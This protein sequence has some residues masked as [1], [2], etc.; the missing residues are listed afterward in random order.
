MGRFG[1][2]VRELIK[3]LEALPQYVPVVCW[4]SLFGDNCFLEIQ[5]TGLVPLRRMEEEQ[6]YLE[7]EDGFDLFGVRL[8]TRVPG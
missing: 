2:T 3:R 1:M 8:L 6:R 5:D 4:S 7:G